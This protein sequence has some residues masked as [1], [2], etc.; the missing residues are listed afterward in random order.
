MTKKVKKSP[1]DVIAPCGIYCDVCPSYEKTCNGCGSVDPN[2]KRISKWSCKI[3][4]CCMDHQNLR[5]CYQCTDFPCKVLKKLQQSHPGNPKFS[6]RHEML[7]NLDDLKRLGE[8][9]WIQLQKKKWTCPKCKGKLLFYANQ[10]PTCGTSIRL[11]RYWVFE[12]SE[13]E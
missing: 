1:W 2:Q 12:E 5:Y 13:D 8:R 6:Y 3:R 11:K 7:D 9:Q 10:C 4:M